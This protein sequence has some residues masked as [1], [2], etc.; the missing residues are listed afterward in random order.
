MN[1]VT[2][3]TQYIGKK[4]EVHTAPFF[5]RP[6]G[7]DNELTAKGIPL[8][9]TGKLVAVGTLSVDHIKTEYLY[10]TLKTG[11]KKQ[12]IPVATVAFVKRL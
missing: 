3:F 4:I 11:T 7:R 2:D 5:H 6:Q 8:T 12:Q 9:H 1:S 10:L